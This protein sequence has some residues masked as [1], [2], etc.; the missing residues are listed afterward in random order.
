MKK[1]LAVLIA[2][3]F[4][5]TSA[6]AAQHMKGDAKKDDGKKSAMKKDDGKKKGAAKKEMKKEEKK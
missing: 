6:Y 5:A 2:A 4:A 3:S 1:L